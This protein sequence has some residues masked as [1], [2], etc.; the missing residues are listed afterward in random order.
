MTRSRRRLIAAALVLATGF[1]SAC[2]PPPWVWRE[3]HQERMERREREERREKQ[4]NERHEKNRKERHERH[5]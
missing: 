3:R 5:H 1:L 4:R 2:P